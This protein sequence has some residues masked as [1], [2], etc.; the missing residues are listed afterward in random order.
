[1][2]PV[3][4]LWPTVLFVVGIILIIKCGDAFVDAAIWISNVTG[5]PRFVVGATVVSIATTLPEMIVSLIATMDGKAGMAFGNVIGSVSCNIGLALGISLIMIPFAKADKSFKL[6]GGLMMLSAVTL[7]LLSLDG[8]ISTLDAIILFVIFAINIYESLT[9]QRG[10]EERWNGRKPD[11]KEVGVNTLKFIIGIGGIILGAQLLVDNGSI[12]ARFFG[13][14]ESIIGLTLIAVGTSLPEIITTVTAIAK[15]EAALS[16]G[17]IFGANIIDMTL[18]IAVCAF[19]GG[20][21]QVPAEMFTINI[22]AAIIFIA[23]AVIPT[24]LAKKFTKL[25]GFA[26]LAA[27]FGYVYLVSFVF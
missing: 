23:L 7:L 27:Y 19:A 26:I 21:M 9:H 8:N 4:I 10:E 1:M 17:N 24:L 3:E 6:K 15:K 5:I 16:V 25:Q 12:I 11:K 18:A 22:P 13:I 2:N 14:P 20:Q